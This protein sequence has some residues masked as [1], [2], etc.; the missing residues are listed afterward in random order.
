MRRFETLI[1]GIRTVLDILHTHPSYQGRGVG[2]QLVK[3]GTDLADK[4]HLQCYVESSPAGYPLFRKC[5]FEDVTEMEIELNKYK[6]SGYGQYKYKHMVMTRPP[7]IPPKVPP[8]DLVLKR[9]P[10][11]YWDFGLPTTEESAENHT[12]SG[13]DEFSDMVSY[14]NTDCG[15]VDA[16][17]ETRQESFRPTSYFGIL[18]TVSEDGEGSSR[19]TSRF[20]SGNTVEESSRPVSLI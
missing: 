3:W 15:I 16:V 19:P 5:D 11:G 7:K 12:D 4:E 8:K 20:M 1:N 9:Y 13:C 2:A 17:G 18:E 14:R 10:V 6:S